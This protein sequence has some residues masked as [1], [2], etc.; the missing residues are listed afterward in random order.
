MASAMVIIKISILLIVIINIIILFFFCIFI[1]V[2]DSGHVVGRLLL[3]YGGG[4]LTRG[5][6]VI[7]LTQINMPL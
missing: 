5:K 6:A 7:M 2:I 3:L 4:I 1:S